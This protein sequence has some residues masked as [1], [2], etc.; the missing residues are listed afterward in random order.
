MRRRVPCAL[1]L[2]LI[3]AGAAACGGSGAT[4]VSAAPVIDPGDA[5]KYRPKIA[6]A[7]FVDAIDHPYLP[8]TPGSRWLYEGVS[9]G[10]PERIEIT[11]TREPR[12]IM[13]I[14]AVVVR[15][16]VH[17]NGELAED[18]YD[19]FAQDRTGN[20]WYL[21]EDSNQYEGG[22]PTP[23]TP[24]AWARCSGRAPSTPSGSGTTGTSW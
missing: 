18:T 4:Q 2:A 6:A 7:D 1:G 16:V 9:D 19:W 21:G 13:G 3:W 10:E 11:V 17:K 20:V 14:S 23:A 8:L 5:G 22:K 12:Q 15:D 24:R